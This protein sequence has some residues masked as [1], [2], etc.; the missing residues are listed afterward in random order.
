MLLD[1]ALVT[2]T[3]LS[4]IEKHVTASPEA[5][6]VTPLTV[7]SLPPDR[8]TGDRTLGL[9]LYHI[10]E[11]A[12]YKNLPPPSADEPPVRFTPMGLNLYYLLAG[13]SDLAGN[14]GAEAEQTMV[15]L[16][17]KALHD[18]PVIDDATTVGGT[19]VFPAAL[20]GTDNRFRVVL[21]PVQ[22]T[23]AMNYW[24]AGSQALRLA[25]YYQ[26]SVVLLE[27][28]PIRSR[29]GRVLSY[30]VS[31]LP[32]GAPHL[33]G[34]RSSVT[35]TV[36]GEA[37]P[38]SVEVR[39]AEA[40]VTGR[41]VFFGSDLAG[42][43]TTLLIRHP[44]FGGLV[45]VGTDWGV[46]ASERE[47][48]ATVQP[49]ASG[50]AIIPGLYSAT[51]KVTMRRVM[52]DQTTREFAKTSNAVPFV[53]TPRIAA[54]LPPDPTGRVVVQGGLF[55]GAG[56]DPGDVEVFVGAQKLP[57]A[58]ATLNPGEFEVTAANTLRFRY[59]VAGAAPGTVV[60]FRMII[61]GAESAPNWLTVP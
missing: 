14:T 1:I 59:P 16:A 23:E 19:P 45:E 28:E 30:G 53:V 13:H 21:Q 33:A 32:R 39:P 15:G 42:D 18:F 9:Y 58:G 31:A 46:V 54:I 44:R 8:L 7:S 5:G 37:T 43:Q 27:P 47:I 26:V 24:A 41:V 35:F 4:L 3:L 10:T 52:P 55:Q 51:A 49:H 57:R 61:N 48:V 50:A 40:P 36:P 12:Q 56:I 20:Q 22:H 2:Q 17:M 11:D 29:A 38:R 25:V 6:K 34:S 60:P